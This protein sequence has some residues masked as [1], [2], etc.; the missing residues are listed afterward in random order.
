[1]GALAAAHSQGFDAGWDAVFDGFDGA[2]APGCYIVRLES[3]DGHFSITSRLTMEHGELYNL[4][5]SG[6]GVC[7][8]PD[9]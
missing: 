9:Y 3:D 2:W 6:E 1:L 5:A 7:G 4:C 8:G